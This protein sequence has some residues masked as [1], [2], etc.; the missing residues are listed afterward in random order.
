MSA[1]TRAGIFAA[2][3]RHSSCSGPNAHTSTDAAH[4]PCAC[5]IA[6]TGVAQARGIHGESSRRRLAMRRPH[7][8][9]R[10]RPPRPPPRRATAAVSI[11][12]A[13]RCAHTAR[14]GRRVAATAALRKK[15]NQ[16]V[17]SLRGSGIR[18]SQARGSSLPGPAPP[19][20]EEPWSRN[21]RRRPEPPWS[22]CPEAGSRSDATT[23]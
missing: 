4:S 20:R 9:A 11:C 15:F 22:R 2:R 7:N 19:H 1:T 14:N 10:N 13:D 12:F 6:T 3:M 17:T 8:L 23:H 16:C 18:S 5:C 21:R